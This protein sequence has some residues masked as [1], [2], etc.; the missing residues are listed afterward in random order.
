MLQVLGC[1]GSRNSAPKAQIDGIE[2]RQKNGA[3]PPGYSTGNN[4]VNFRLKVYLF[5]EM[6]VAKLI[7]SELYGLNRS[8]RVQLSHRGKCDPTT[9]TQ[10]YFIHKAELLWNFC[11]LEAKDGF[12]VELRTG[13]CTQVYSFLLYPKTSPILSIS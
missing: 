9:L 3:M 5:P 13:K 6:F 1:C 4:V 7:G 10:L 2:P 11:M 12:I 8:K